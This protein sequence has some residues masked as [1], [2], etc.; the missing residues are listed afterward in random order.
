MNIFKECDTIVLDELNQFKT[1]NPQM[2][3]PPSVEMGGRVPLIFGNEQKLRAMSQKLTENGQVELGKLA[4]PCACF[5]PH[6]YWPFM[7]RCGVN[8]MKVKPLLEI[9]YTYKLFTL[10]FKESQEVLEQIITKFQEPYFTEINRCEMKLN[11]V[12]NNLDKDDDGVDAKI[13][14]HTFNFSLTVDLKKFKNESTTEKNTEP[15]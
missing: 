5:Y 4:L 6:G 8:D 7:Q 12:T 14:I 15:C 3:T 11:S 10:Y 9:G 13:I 1:N 2:M